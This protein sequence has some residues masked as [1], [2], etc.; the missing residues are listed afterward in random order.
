MAVIL[1]ATLLAQYATL[2]RL[3]TFLCCR[4]KS[5]LLRGSD[6]FFL[7]MIRN[8]LNNDLSI[9]GE[10]KSLLRNVNIFEKIRSYRRKNETFLVPAKSALG[11]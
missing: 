7:A 10:N 4:Q 6:D 1:S 2:V 3:N 11:Q 5:K 8:R 9:F